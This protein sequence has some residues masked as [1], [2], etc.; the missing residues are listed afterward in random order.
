MTTT[1]HSPDDQITI[2]QVLERL[3]IEYSGENRVA[4]NH[5]IERGELI[6][7]DRPG[8][9]FYV[10]WG[11]V[12]EYMEKGTHHQRRR[13][14]GVPATSEEQPAHLGPSTDCGE[15]LE[16]ATSPEATAID[17][18]ID[19]DNRLSQIRVPISDDLALM[20]ELAEAETL[21]AS[22]ATLS[23]A[24][25][26]ATAKLHAVH[27]GEFATAIMAK[28][29]RYLV[30]A[31]QC[32]TALNTVKGTRSHGTFGP[33]L[34]EFAAANSTSVRSLQRFMKVARLSSDIRRLLGD[35]Q[36]HRAAYRVLGVAGAQADTT[37]AI[38]AGEADETDEGITESIETKANPGRMEGKVLASA[39][40]F[41]K[42]VRQLNQ[43]GTHLSPEA[44]RQLVLVSEELLNL[45]ARNEV[46]HN[47]HD[48]A[49]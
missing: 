41:Q 11:D 42:S 10:R 12:L 2:R 44:V 17:F 16:H 24:E 45:I 8:R 13:M 29:R 20:T 34:E 39:T 48:H 38:D 46:T 28:G 26:M 23:A 31:W 36:S 14:T 22:L 32:G 35:F 7:V 21:A 9:K 43:T 6:R 27:A 18:E 37:P 1:D 33:W 4:F 5:A 15:M 40:N 25:L 30:A 19:G 49:A 3:G 47:S